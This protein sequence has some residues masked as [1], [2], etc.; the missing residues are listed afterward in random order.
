MKRFAIFSALLLLCL[1]LASAQT[2]VHYFYGDGCP[3]CANVEASGVLE[4]VA[5]ENFT[6]LRYEVYFNASNQVIFNQYINQL[7]L[8]QAQRG[9]PLAVIECIRT[10]TTSLS[11][12]SGDTSIINNLEAQVYKCEATNVTNETGGINPSKQVTLASIVVGAAV[13]SI[14][15]CAFAVLIFLIVTMLAMG[16]K[17]R[18]LRAAIVYIAAVYITYF[19]AGLGIFQVI[20]SLT[21]ITHYVYL[22]SGVIVLIAGLI[23]IR[24]FFWCDGKSILKIPDKAKPIIENIARKGTLPAAILLGFLVSLFE[25]PCTG[26]IYLAILTMMSQHQN[27]SIFY[28]LLYNFIFILPLIIITSVIYIGASPETIEKCRLGGRRWMKLAAGL[29][30]LALG[31]YI[32]VF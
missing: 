12:L 29:V 14:N 7:N 24:E 2:T 19:L 8:P 15:P 30:L 25:L 4:K 32:L 10:N 13:D 17:R 31:I 5:S 20:Q 1:A 23:E 16:S 9:I 22:A 3:H 26:G 28:L 11:Y 27:F 21:S 18:M 6:V